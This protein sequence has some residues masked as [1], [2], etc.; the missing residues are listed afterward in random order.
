MQVIGFAGDLFH[1]L[2]HRKALWGQIRDSSSQVVLRSGSGRQTRI[3]VPAD[4]RDLA[5]RFRRASVVSRQEMSI[6]L[7]R[8]G[9]VLVTEPL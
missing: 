7:V 6:E 3:S 5:P 8:D 9:D 2:G 4:V 1:A